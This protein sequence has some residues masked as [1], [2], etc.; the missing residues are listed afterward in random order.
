MTEHN[1]PRQTVLLAEDKPD[2]Q[3]VTRMLLEQCGCRV[4]EAKDGEEAV[5][6]AVSEHPD[7]ILLDL[8]MPVVDGYEAARRIRAHPEMRG[9]PMVA[10]TAYYSYSLTE[11]A[12]EAGFDEYIVKPINFDDMRKLIERHLP[13]S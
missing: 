4:I 13:E 11:G 12:T 6:L 3:Y 2:D 7:I 9:V 8:R 1:L 10:Y 5:A